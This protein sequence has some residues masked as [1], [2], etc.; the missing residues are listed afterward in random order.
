MIYR[1]REL[2]FARPV[3]AASICVLAAGA[4]GGKRDNVSMS[5]LVG[6]PGSGAD[7]QDVISTERLVLRP[8]SPAFAQAILD[9][10]LTEHDVAVDYPHRDTPDIARGVI[11]EPTLPTNGTWIITRKLD[12]AIVGDCGWFAFAGTDNAVEIGYGLAE[13][14][15]GQGLA[16][17]AVAALLERLATLGVTRIFATTDDHNHASARVLEKLGFQLRKTC[18]GQRRYELFL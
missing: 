18:R 8:F 1:H 5:S 13:T 17:E 7:N 3:V 15:R 16:T 2:L 14:V 12:G 9:G 6:P 10:D 11:D 4:C